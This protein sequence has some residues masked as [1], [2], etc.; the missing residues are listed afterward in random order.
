MDKQLEAREVAFKIDYR[1]RDGQRSP[2]FKKVLISRFDEGTEDTKLEGWVSRH[3][4]LNA[5]FL[6]L[7][8]QR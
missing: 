3:G 6:I 5:G 8:Y 7:I 2:A 1:K 4:S